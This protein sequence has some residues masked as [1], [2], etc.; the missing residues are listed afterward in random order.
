MDILKILLGQIPEA[1]Y[2]ALF[3]ILVKQLKTKRLLYTVLMS[4]EY[5]LLFYT[6]PNNI[7]ARVLY[8]VCTYIVL[9]LLYKEKSQITD[10][11]TM[12]IASL[13][14]TIIGA[15]TYFAFYN[16]G[17]IVA[18]I[19]NRVCLFLP[20]YL[21]RNKLPNIQKMYK[22]FWNRNDKIP[23]RMKSTTFRCV[24][25]VVFNITFYL[26]NAI[27]IYCLLNRR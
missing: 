19:I 9:K 26:L 3:M 21:L 7:W 27:I 14:I 12:G 2:F 16:M 6:F 11:F 22:K 25:L 15:V 20:L 10:I 4:I 17:Y 18:L 5:A 23:K 8:F 1:I 13:Y 24:N